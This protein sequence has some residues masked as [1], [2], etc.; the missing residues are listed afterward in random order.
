M[1]GDICRANDCRASD[2]RAS[3]R[4]PLRLLRN[5]KR[6]TKNSQCVYVTSQIPHRNVLVMLWRGVCSVEQRVNAR[7]LFQ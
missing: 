1:L 3:E 4:L 6:L 7:C 2:C 5:I